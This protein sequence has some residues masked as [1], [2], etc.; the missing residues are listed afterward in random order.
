VVDLDHRVACGDGFHDREVEECDPEDEGSWAH[1]CNGVTDPFA[2]PS[3]DPTACTLQCSFCGDGIVDD[4]P[5]ADG[6]P[7]EE[8]DPTDIHQL[9][10]PRLC[11]GAGDQPPLRSPRRALK[12]YTSGT[13]IGCLADCTYDRSNCG[14][15][16]DGDVDG[17]DVANAI[18]TLQIV[19]DSV[20]EQCDGERFDLDALVEEFTNCASTDGYLVANVGCTETCSFGE[21]RDPACC[22]RGGAPCPADDE[23]AR[24][25]HELDVP[26]A[27][28]HCELGWIG[29]TGDD[30]G[31]GGPVCK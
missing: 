28:E 23:V 14:F 18:S 9:A 1:A 15:C 5:K 24:C 10:A 16:G 11:A 12:P 13:A 20:P 2:Q 27:T 8:C 31:D 19:K 25:C 3:C 17:E 21:R 4:T 29:T 30:T 6:D 26:D 7:R 22:L